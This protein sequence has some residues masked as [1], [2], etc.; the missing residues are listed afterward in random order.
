MTERVVT[1]VPTHLG[2]HAET[3]AR[4]FG[5]F[6]ERAGDRMLVYVPGQLAHE[7]DRIGKAVDATVARVM[8]ELP[9]RRRELESE[10]S[11]RA[12]CDEV[13]ERVL[14]GAS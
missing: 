10:E 3:I 12:R 13:V 1:T 4:R 6:A 7:G 5:A 8:A 9:E 11:W 14:G 2:R